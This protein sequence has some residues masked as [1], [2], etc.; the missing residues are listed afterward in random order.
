MALV[1]QR[2][3]AIVVVLFVIA[4]SPPRAIAQRARLLDRVVAVVDGTVILRSDVL[5]MAKAV[6]PR[7]TSCSSDAALSDPRRVLEVMIETRLITSHARR[8]GLEVSDGEVDARIDATAAHQQIARTAMDAEVTK[9]GFSV[10]EYR[11]IVRGQL[12]ERKWTHEW[13]GVRALVSLHGDA[14]DRDEAMR[15]AL[16]A[17]RQRALAELRAAVHVEVRW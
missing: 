9:Y 17:A 10:A 12:L 6:D 5:R 15:R 3:T 7:R 16:E 2:L 1:K 14:S 4:G 8:L 11:E 13:L